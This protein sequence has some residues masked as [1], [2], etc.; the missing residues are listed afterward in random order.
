MDSL[1][2]LVLGASVGVAVMG[3]GTRTSRA[4][5]WG[6]LAGT[7]PDL[8]VL[9]DQ[10]DPILD[11]VLHRAESHAF[12]WQTLFSLPLA[13]AVARL[14]HETGLWLRWWAALWLALVTH[15]LLDLLT[16]Y[17]TQVLLPFSSQAWGLGSVFVIDPL[18]T[19]PWAAGLVAALRAATPERARRVNLI[20]LSIGLAYLGWGAAVQQHVL[21]QARASLRLQGLPAV[22]VLATPAP[23]NSLLWRV[24]S[25]GDG[26]YHEGF[27]SLLDAPGPMRFES[28]DQGLPLAAALPEH[29][30]LK[31]IQA[32]SDGFWALQEEPDGR[33]LLSDLRMGQQPYYVFRFAIARRDA[34]TGAWR[35]MQPTESAGGRAPVAASLSWLWQRM[36]GRPLA[37]PR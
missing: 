15:P 18:A 3:R 12:F 23:F 19:L 11:M 13:L 7:L 17:G 8:D 35:P 22:Q 5:A 37:P 31:R 2:Q 10:G 25:T 32:F 21:D 29:D 24:V 14:H 30:G 34:V 16:I 33:L 27:L 36:L 6:A 20:G 26:R 28:F 9:I 1:T 4:A